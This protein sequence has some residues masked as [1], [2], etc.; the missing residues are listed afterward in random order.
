MQAVDGEAPPDD[1]TSLSTDDIRV[2]LQHITIT[3]NTT[4]RNWGGTFRCFPRGVFEPEDESH[5]RLILELARREGVTVR[6]CGAGHSPSDLAC[7]T[8]YLLRTNKLQRV[9]QVRFYSIYSH[10]T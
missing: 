2:A 10:V 9:L 5:C 1:F 8:G 3:H 6:A 4:F 7:T